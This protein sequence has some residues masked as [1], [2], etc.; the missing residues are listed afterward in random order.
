MNPHQAHMIPKWKQALE[1]DDG[2]TCYEPGLENCSHVDQREIMSV[3]QSRCLRRIYP[4]ESSQQT[5]EA[6]LNTRPFVVVIMH[7]NQV[8][9]VQ[10]FG[11]GLFTPLRLIAVALAQR[12]GWHTQKLFDQKSTCVDMLE[13]PQHLIIQT[14]NTH[15]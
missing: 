11:P 14:G 8:E 6:C 7:C 9:T 12:E 10:A 2:T 3:F 5:H 1:S 13:K 4:P 15:R